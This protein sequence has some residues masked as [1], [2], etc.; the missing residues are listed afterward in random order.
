MQRQMLAVVSYAKQIL[1]SAAVTVKRKKSHGYECYKK[2]VKSEYVPEK[3][4]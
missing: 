4:I 1:T 2:K 3:D